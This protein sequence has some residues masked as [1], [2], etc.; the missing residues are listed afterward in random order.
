[1]QQ[2]TLQSKTEVRECSIHNGSAT[3]AKKTTPF[4]TSIGGNR[5]YE[6]SMLPDTWTTLTRR[7]RED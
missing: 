5:V 7:L 3:G 1:M 2:A 6:G 4:E